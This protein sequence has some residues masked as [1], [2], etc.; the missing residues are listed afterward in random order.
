MT[1]S[2]DYARPAAPR[3]Q[4][5]KTVRLAILECDTPMTQTKARYGGYGGVFAALLGAAG[6]SMGMI[7]GQEAEVGFEDEL[8]AGHESDE[9]HAR[10]PLRLQLSAHPIQAH[11][12]TA[13]P[14]GAD[15]DAVLI[16]GSSFSAYDDGQ[17]WIV[18]LVSFV[19]ELLLGEGTTPEEGEGE[20]EGRRRKKV[21]GVCFGHQIIGRALGG[22]VAPCELAHGW[23]TSVCEMDLTDAGRGLFFPANDQDSPST[24]VRLASLFSF[25]FFADERE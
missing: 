20:D 23:E 15:F 17:A 8:R 19:R 2:A 5:A 3:S 9:K 18:K 12:D 10:P 16:S 13:Y 6:K 4:K 25:L 24:L 14:S 7:E 11:P 21:I 1:V 22:T